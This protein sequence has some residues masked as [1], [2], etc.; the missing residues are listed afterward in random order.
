[1]IQTKAQ[2]NPAMKELKAEMSKKN[3]SLDH[4]REL[5]VDL[6]GFTQ[7]SSVSGH[8][9]SLY[10][11][12]WSKKEQTVFTAFSE[13]NLYSVAWHLWHAARIEDITCSYF[14][15]GEEEIFDSGNFQ[16]R[17]KIPFRHTGVSLDYIQM[18]EL[19]RTADLECLHEYRCLV[20]ERT[21]K[22]FKTLT[23]E[24]LK[25][26]VS[27]SALVRI[28]ELG[29]VAPEDEWLLDFWGKKKL[30]GIVT[31]PLTRHLLVHLNSAL[32]LI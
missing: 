14:I 21:Q 10:D 30:F 26:K 2:W 5:M 4:V 3:A 16:N 13:K 9:S 6:H 20:G 7:C 23:F 24:R 1:M 18:T 15:C 12:L 31:M 19:N 29:S 27:P 32:R 11:E 25:E 17:L 28:A 8:K 22:V